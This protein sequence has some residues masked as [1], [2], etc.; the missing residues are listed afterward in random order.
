MGR[1]DRSNTTSLQKTDVKQ[2]LAGKSSNDCSRLGEAEGCVRLLLT[3]NHPRFFSCASSLSPVPHTRILSC[4]VGTFTKIQ[5]HIHMTPRPR[6]TI[7]GSHKKLLRA[8]IEPATRCAAA[9][10][11]AT[12]PTVQGR[13]GISSNDCS[14][15]GEAG[16][17]VR[18]LLTKNHS[19]PSPALRAGAPESTF[20]NEH[21]ASL[22]DRS[23]ALA[24]ASCIPGPDYLLCRGCVYKHTSSHTHG[25]QT[26]NNNL[27]ITQSVVPCGNR[28]RD[29]LHGS[30]LPSHRTNRAVKVNLRI[31]GK[32][33]I[34]E[35]F[36]ETKETSLIRR[37]TTQALVYFGFQLGS[38]ITPVEPAHSCRSMTLQHSRVRYMFYPPTSALFLIHD[39]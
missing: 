1:L 16:G 34:G 6:T 23:S 5:V 12:A 25:T 17:S 14:R 15:L 31:V 21:L 26:R 32:S 24:E 2:R 11:P 36:I 33:G 22:T 7:C 19:V 8:G 28:T 30:R 37:N 35:I 10:C 38:G 4:V 20:W 13:G 9:G 29:T 39:L 27:W 18:L 3:K